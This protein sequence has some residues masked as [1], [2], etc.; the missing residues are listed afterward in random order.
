M[1]NMKKIALA[2]AICCSAGTSLAQE[3]INPSWY[4][5][6]TVVGIKPD[7]DFGVDDKDWGGGLKFGKAVHP[8]WDIQIGATHARA[9]SGPND[10]RQTL[11]G[12]DALLMLSRQQIRPFVLFGVG[13]E[14]D[15]V[16]NPL[17]HVKKTSPY[18]T[19]GLGVQVGLNDR[20]SLQADLRTVRGHLRDDEQF[21]FSRSN[22]KYLMVGLNYAFNPPPAPPAP[23]PTP[24]PAP[25]PVAEQPAPQPA[26]V[27]PPPP[28]AR[29]EKV[30]LSATELFGFNSATLNMPQPKLDDI[31]AA[32]QAD[33]SITD[34]DITGYTDRLG[35]TKYNQKLS[36]RRANAVRD[37][38][39]GKGID[40]SR[41]KAVGRGEEN[42]VVTC[43][44]KKRSELIECLAPNRRVEVEQITVERR[45]Q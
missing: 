45:V 11:L 8:M 44:Q 15:K 29:F 21:G 41:L 2:V 33:T 10:Y 4:I 24:A 16:S 37:Y 38:L 31:A 27:A 35:S 7:A 40:G 30:T 13:A 9:D 18:Y 1:N 6:P 5:Q 19:V 39:I 26:P 34:V 23:A 20:W 17:R 3:V 12:V 28:P 36:L 25:A 22:N 32:L 14:R 42:P 43:N